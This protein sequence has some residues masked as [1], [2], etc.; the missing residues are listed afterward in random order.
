MF[1][2]LIQFAFVF[3]FFLGSLNAHSVDDQHESMDEELATEQYQ[4]LNVAKRSASCS[5]GL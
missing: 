4:T 1:R 3:L 5:T 2:Y